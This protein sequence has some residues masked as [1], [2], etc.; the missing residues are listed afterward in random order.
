MSDRQTTANKATDSVTSTID[1]SELAKFTA[2]AADWWNPNGQFKPLHKFNPTRLAY[3]RDKLCAQFDRDPQA[4]LPLK[5]LRLLDIGCGGGL[6]SEPMARLGAEVV[7]ADAGEANIKTAALHAEQQGLDIDYRA[8]TAEELV[9]QGEVFDAVLN[10]E[11]IEHVADPQAFMNACGQLMKPDAIMFLATLNRTLKAFALAIIGAE[12]VL[13]WLP[14]GTHDWDKFITPK[15]LENMADK[16][17]LELYS[18]TGVSFNPLTDKWRQT[19]DLSV[20]YMGVARKSV[21]Q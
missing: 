21:T 9:T 18:S 3:I 15:E 19:G 10:M 14:R 16:A 13:R 7:G 11:V 4:A 8:I 12:Y 6:L 20:N 1:P 2:M 5:G 17:G